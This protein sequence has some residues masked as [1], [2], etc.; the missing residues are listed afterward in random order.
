MDVEYLD[1]MGNDLA[2]VNAARVSFSKT[3]E[4]LPSGS[5]SDY[6]DVVYQNIDGNPVNLKQGDHKLIQ[7]LARHNHWTPFAHTAIKLRVSAP[8]PI[9]TQCFKHKSGLVENE[10]SRR[11]ITTTPELFI[12]DSFR[13]APMGNVKQGSGEAH[14]FSKQWLDLY[15]RVG[16]EAIAYYQ[17]MID[18]GICPEQARFILPQGVEVNWVWTGNLASYARFFNQRTDPHAQKEIQYLAEEVGA[19]IEPLFPVSWKAL[20]A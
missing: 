1:H 6:P 4:W 15:Q 18:A 9:R 12:P 14:Y 10:E 8:V 5:T 17:M 7:Y 19:I 11:Y 20:T 3:S 2:V 16:K 13:E